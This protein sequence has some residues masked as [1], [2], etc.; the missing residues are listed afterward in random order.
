MNQILNHGLIQRVR[1]QKK[2]SDTNQSLPAK[3]KEPPAPNLI[4]FDDDK[5]GNDDDEDA[6]W[7]AGWESIDTK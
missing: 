6:G 4:T 7:D 5:W 2:P 3:P 1:L